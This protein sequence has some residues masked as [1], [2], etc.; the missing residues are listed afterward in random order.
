MKDF[1]VE[2]TKFSLFA[3]G[4]N[5]PAGQK[6]YQTGT[7]Q[8]V[9]QLIH[10]QWLKKLTDE[11]RSLKEVEAQQK[12]KRERL[13]FVTFSGT[14]EH[15]SEQGLIEHSGLQCF[16]FDHIE[17]DDELKKVRE[18]L[19]GDPVFETDLLFRSP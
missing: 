3:P 1:K 14:F 18:S 17:S 5:T 11:L 15:R 12:F 4:I 19:L 8:D 10:S 6:P 7:L 16:D 9:W 2:E 13:P